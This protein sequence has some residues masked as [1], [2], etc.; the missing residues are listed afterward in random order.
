MWRLV[1]HIR[2][3]KGNGKALKSDM[4]YSPNFEM[5]TVLK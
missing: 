1:S 3:E 4:I 5:S 2:F